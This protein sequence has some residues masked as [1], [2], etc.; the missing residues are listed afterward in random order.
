MPNESVAENETATIPALV[1]DISM[2]GEPYT[3]PD[4]GGY[5]AEWL[6]KAE[7]AV[8]GKGG[9]HRTWSATRQL[10]KRYMLIPPTALNLLV[11]I[12]NPRCTPPWEPMELQA[13][14]ERA[15]QG[16]CGRLA[17]SNENGTPSGVDADM[18]DTAYRIILEGMPL[19]VGDR[20]A[21]R[22]RGLTDEDIA[23]EGYRSWDTSIDR[24]KASLAKV[25]AELGDAMYTVPGIYKTDFGP[26]LGLPGAGLAVAVRDGYGRVV[27]IRVRVERERRNKKGFTVKGNDGRP[28]IE[29]TYLW[30]SGRTDH[31]DDPRAAATCHVPVHAPDLDLST[32]AIT[33]GEI[34]ANIATEKTGLLYVSV[35]GVGSWRAGL[36]QAKALGAKTILV[37]YDAD[38]IDKEGVAQAVVSTFDTAV[39]D[40]LIVAIETWAQS[41]GKGIDDVLVTNP[42]AIRKLEGDEAAVHVEQLVKKHKMRRRDRRAEQMVA[43]LDAAAAEE[44]AKVVAAFDAAAELPPAVEWKKLLTYTSG[45]K[46]M[47]KPTPHNVEVF[48]RRHPDWRGARIGMDEFRQ[49]L[50]WMSPPPSSWLEHYPET[51]ATV[52]GSTW[53][54]HDT[55]KLLAVL[56]REGIEP[57]RDVVRNVVQSVAMANTFHPVREYLLE[58]EKR[59]DGK[60]RLGVVLAGKEAG[61]S[62]LHEYLG[63][64]D[65]EYVRKVGTWWMVQAVR[66]IFEPGAL[67]KYILTLEGLQDRGKSTALEILCGREWFSDT[68]ME[69]GSLNGMLSLSGVWVQ[70]IA[71]GALLTRHDRKALKGWISKKNDHY[72]PKWSN[73]AVSVPRQV[74]F[75]MTTNEHSYLT[76][77]TG[78]VRWWPVPITA[79]KFDELARDRDQL[80]GEAA[81]LYKA[82]MIPEPRS[83]AD[84]L[85]LREEVGERQQGDVWETKIRG[86]AGGPRRHHRRGDPG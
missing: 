60:P 72:T 65:N 3:M 40:G 47:P 36:E 4:T 64:A 1:E 52:R 75:A 9:R 30:L 48:L 59:W 33:E 45:K 84:K 68:E 71:E 14:V 28:I 32:V 86:M 20:N 43:I 81:Y 77:P 16:R 49:Q 67:A 12:Y 15:W 83:E 18:L 66:R 61:S 76:D 22:A 7:P 63:A 10:I 38:A 39:A 46:P 26:E 29:K 70:E 57:G 54:D 13:M 50:V 73:I 31:R 42:K 34:K 35:P 44:E 24:R 80:W 79:V 82:G 11:E 2:E 6:A 25:H 74:V 17:A 53:T 19:H 21:L 78:A 5:A 37:S 51:V 85:L 62:W 23:R 56:N 58:A 69:L 55:T 41:F 27:G 8:S